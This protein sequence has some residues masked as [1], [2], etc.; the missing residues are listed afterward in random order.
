MGLFLFNVIYCKLEFHTD[1]E[2]KQ[3]CQQSPQL[4]PIVHDDIISDVCSKRKILK[5]SLLRQLED[6]YYKDD[7][8]L[9][10]IA[11]GIFHAGEIGVRY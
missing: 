1:A 5:W 11:Q 6:L 3:R 2:V 9:S 7:I 8:C 10:T 4:F